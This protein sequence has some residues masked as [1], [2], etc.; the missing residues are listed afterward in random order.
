MENC[1]RV[2]WGV[3]ARLHTAS[4]GLCCAIHFPLIF[5][6]ATSREDTLHDIGAEGSDMTRDIQVA[7]YKEEEFRAYSQSMPNAAVLLDADLHT[8]SDMAR[9]GGFRRTHV[10]QMEGDDAPKAANTPFM[11]I[12]SRPK[13][14]QQ[15]Q[16]AYEAFIRA[17]MN[18]AQDEDS[19]E[20]S[21]LDEVKKPEE[22]NSVRKTV[23]ALLK[24]FIGA[25]ILF[26]PKGFENGGLT[27][28]L[29]VLTAACAIATY[30]MLR[31][32]ECAKKLNRG[33]VSYGL[34]GEKAFGPWGRTA[35]NTALVLSQ[36][37]F[38]CS[39]LIF[40]GSNLQ[41]VIMHLSN[42]RYQP[43]PWL[44][45]LLQIPVYTPMSWIRKIKYFSITNLIADVLIIFGL[46][47]IMR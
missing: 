1:A 13:S 38:C 6:M 27:F 22:G 11:S 40:I 36:L 33:S 31:L 37:G 39:Y 24:S 34:V 45:I 18:T 43:G 46:M 28:S 23:F 47:Y 4:H 21:L 3:I 2:I 42:C 14:Y 35:V 7:M 10:L 16:S 20:E 5:E 44:L 9:P 32:S 15:V 17:A 8:A 19:S 29:V 25:G 12:V 26:L 41:D 30:C